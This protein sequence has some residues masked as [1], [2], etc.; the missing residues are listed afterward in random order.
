MYRWSLFIVYFLDSGKKQYQKSN[1]K[2]KKKN[3]NETT[4]TEIILIENQ[5]NTRFTR[6]DE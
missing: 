2:E 5:S 3:E 6:I 4:D 1:E